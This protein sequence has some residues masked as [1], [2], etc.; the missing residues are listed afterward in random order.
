[1]A[2]PANQQS[3]R[4]REAPEVRVEQLL[5]AA[6]EMLLSRGPQASI[7]EIAET[8]GVA[9]GTLYL[10]FK[11]KQELLAAL[12]QRYV[13]G[14]E[15]KVRKAVDSAS[16]ADR[17]HDA[18][19]ALVTAGSERPELHHLLFQE[20]GQSEDDAFGP[21]RDLLL[22]IVGPKASEFTTEFVLGGVHAAMIHAAHVPK[23]HR[24]QVAEDTARLVSS[25]TK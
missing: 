4:R 10:Y 17:T 24:A 16:A 21:I 9:K 14:I 22:E 7:A 2:R 6:E 11:S 3:M 25:L 18:V 1:M 19:V 5:D 15:S 23:V 8:A 13:E 12:R 20:A